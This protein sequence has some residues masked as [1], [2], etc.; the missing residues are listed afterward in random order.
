MS[1]WVEENYSGN[2]LIDREAITELEQK[3]KNLQCEKDCSTCKADC[4]K[5]RSNCKRRCAN[6]GCLD[7]C[8]FQASSCIS[9][10]HTYKGS[11]KPNCD[12]KCDSQYPLEDRHEWTKHCIITIDSPGQLVFLT[13]TVPDRIDLNPNDFRNRRRRSQRHPSS[14]SFSFTPGPATINIKKLWTGGHTLYRKLFLFQ[15]VN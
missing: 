8:D 13:T 10:C 2:F 6:P 11:I 4:E 9:G 15:H 3:A 12:K 1:Q 5:N 14:G 7:D